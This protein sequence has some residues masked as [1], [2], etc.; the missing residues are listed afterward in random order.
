[1]SMKKKLRVFCHGV[2][3]V[4][5]FENVSYGDIWINRISTRLYRRRHCLLKPAQR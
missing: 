3:D 1:M 4:E 5:N 2:Q